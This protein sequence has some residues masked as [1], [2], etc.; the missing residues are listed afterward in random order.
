M[1]TDLSRLTRRVMCGILWFALVA[2]VQ[3]GAAAGDKKDTEK[4]DDKSIPADLV[5]TTWVGTEALDGY[6]HLEFRFDP[7]NKCI[8]KDAD[9]A[10]RGTTVPGGFIYDAKTGKVVV[11]F[12][13]ASYEGV[14]RGSSM[15]GSALMV[16]AKTKKSVKWTWQLKR[17]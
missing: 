16:D 3:Q 1:P 7:K 15:S 13:N 2:L 14:A 17:K 4:K 11:T 12:A 5:G 9:S 8:M 6:G 10:K